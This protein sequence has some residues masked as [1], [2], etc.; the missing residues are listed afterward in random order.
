MI[1][2]I[3]EQRFASYPNPE[4]QRLADGHHARMFFRDVMNMML[5]YSEG[6][7]VDVSLVSDQSLSALF[8]L[9]TSPNRSYS[10]ERPSRSNVTDSL[11][12]FIRYVAD[13][14]AFQGASY[15]EI[16]STTDDQTKPGSP[17]LA[18][19]P[20]KIEVKGTTLRQHIPESERERVGVSHIDLPIS[21]AW[22][23]ELPERLG[24]ES[25]HYERLK[26]LALASVTV[27]KFYDESLSVGQPGKNYVMKEHSDAQFVAVAKAMSDWGWLGT[28]WESRTVTEYYHRLRTLKFHMTLAELRVAI[29]DDMNDLLKRL[30]IQSE[31]RLAGVLRPSEIQKCIDRFKD[32][33]ISLSDVRE[34]TLAQL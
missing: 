13:S 34:I 8:H 28:Y 11:T 26:A 20:G 25:K 14:L 31:I 6:K 7:G 1:E 19:I 24:D 16:V 9:F 33:Q 30:D 22:I 10:R 18:V 2:R 4:L 17:I 29:V 32:G 12:E 23:V 21:K 15:W 5:P 27:P 3:T